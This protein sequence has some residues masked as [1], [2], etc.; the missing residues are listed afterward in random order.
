[1]GFHGS[2]HDSMADY[3]LAGDP[4]YCQFTQRNKAESS[5]GQRAEHL[6]Q[7]RDA[8]YRKVHK[9]SKKLKGT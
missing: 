9:L 7:T 5:P 1:M 6:K 4:G 3:G 8:L 2:D